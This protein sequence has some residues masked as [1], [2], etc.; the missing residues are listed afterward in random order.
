M[1]APLPVTTTPP[2]TSSSGT[3]P[4]G[5]TTISQAIP[6][7][8][9]PTTIIPTA[10]LPITTAWT[11][12]GARIVVGA[13]GGRLELIEADA[14]GFDPAPLAAAATGPL[15]VVA[16]LPYNVGTERLLGWRTQTGP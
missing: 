6:T 2:I 7:R 12:C 13:S 10:K 11:A 9:T 1:K 5:Q 4:T 15:L 16:N 14:L 3:V 8:P